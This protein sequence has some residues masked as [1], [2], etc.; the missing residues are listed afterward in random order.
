MG[1]KKAEFWCPKCGKSKGIIFVSKIDGICPSQ[2]PC[3]ECRNALLATQAIGRV[4][5][6]KNVP[7]KDD[8]KEKLRIASTGQAAWNKGIPMSEESKIKVACSVR[9]LNIEEFD[10]FKDKEDR[11]KYKE[12]CLSKSCFE[13]ANFTCKVCGARGV[14]LN[15]HHMNGWHSHVEDRYSL[16][17]LVCLC[18][19]CH[20][21]FHTQYGNGVKEPNTKE[22]FQEFLIK[23]KRNE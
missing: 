21:E 8:I 5:W 14:E 13:K 22:Q 1:K 6:N 2:R 11:R 10:G 9:G 7:M 23:V 12:M 19:Q 17:N 16:D 15:A 4:P 3:K 20:R 18:Y